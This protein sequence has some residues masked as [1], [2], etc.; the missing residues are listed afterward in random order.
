MANQNLSFVKNVTMHTNKMT[1]VSTALWRSEK[2]Q[3]DDVA[4]QN[5]CSLDAGC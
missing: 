2:N 3:I 4:G 5:I 1:T